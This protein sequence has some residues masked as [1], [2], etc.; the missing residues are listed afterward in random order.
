MTGESL[1]L[2]VRQWCYIYVYI[3]GVGSVRISNLEP[4]RLAGVAWSITW[5]QPK[6][7]SRK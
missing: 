4:C 5:D 2:D 7:E 1:M 3:F 6:E